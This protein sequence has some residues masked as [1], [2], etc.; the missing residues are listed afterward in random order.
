MDQSQ[1]TNQEIDLFQNQLQQEL[2]KIIE[3]HNNRVN[4]EMERMKQEKLELKEKFEQEISELKRKHR[5][6]IEKEK[7]IQQKSSQISK[8]VFHLQIDEITNQ[9]E[10][11]GGVNNYTQL[12]DNEVDKMIKQLQGMV[13]RLKKLPQ[14]SQNGEEYE[15]LQ[16]I[17]KQQKI[18][19]M[20]MLG[21]MKYCCHQEI[22]QLY[23][24]HAIIDKT[25][26]NFFRSSVDK[27]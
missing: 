17:Y 10:E 26:Y 9:K 6:S 4:A 16:T 11:T 27:K 18:V 15:L 2:Q 12:F 5:Q 3:E 8:Q 24:K 23:A 22:Q 13:K 21:I 19:L 25:Y 20:K 1:E 7:L 14:R